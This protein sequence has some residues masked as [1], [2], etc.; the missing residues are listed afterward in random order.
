MTKFN[1][2]PRKKLR[3][4][5]H[6]TVDEA[7]LAKLKAAAFEQAKITTLTADFEAAFAD[8]DKYLQLSRASEYSAQLAKADDERDKLYSLIKQSVN[9]WILV[10]IEPYL[11]S[12]QAI[13]RLNDTYNIDVDE[14]Y[15]EETGKLTN[16][17]TD[18]QTDENAAHLAKLGLTDPVTLLKERNEQVKTLLASRAEERGAKVAGALKAAREKTDELYSEI[19]SLI[20]SCSL[21]MD[22]T[23]PY[24]TFISEWNVEVDRIKQ[25]LNRKTSSASTTPTKE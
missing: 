11:T 1:T 6:F 9:S 12:A 23:T 5:A 8:E 20:E 22:D 16:W 3:N 25:Q 2:L 19:T 4:A 21:L 15:D 17:L 18:A 14:Q 10:A 13:G 24:E 7:F